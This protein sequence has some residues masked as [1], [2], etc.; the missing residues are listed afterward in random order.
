MG[1]GQILSENLRASLFNDDLSNEPTFSQIHL[2]G[3]NNGGQQ[4]RFEP[5]AVG[6]K[7]F[8]L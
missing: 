6:F 7:Y 4:G 3:Q 1:D 5:F 8:V 2:G